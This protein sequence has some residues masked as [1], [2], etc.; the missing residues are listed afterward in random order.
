MFRQASFIEHAVGNLRRALLAGAVLVFIVL[1]LFLGHLRT[2][3]VSVVAIPLS[4]LAAVAILRAA[5]ATLNTMVLGG[6]AIAVGEVVDDA[7][8]DVENVWRRLRAAPR[9]EERRVGEECRSPW[10]PHH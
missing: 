3:L 7:I 10:S 4:L 6:L 9:S 1:L 2:V 5:G 8:I